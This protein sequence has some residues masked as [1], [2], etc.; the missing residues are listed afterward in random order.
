MTR[1]SFHT[2]MCRSAFEW[3]LEESSVGFMVLRPNLYCGLP[4]TSIGFHEHWV[5]FNP[6]PTLMRTAKRVWQLK[7]TPERRLRSELKRLLEE[8]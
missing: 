7:G 4:V 6:S 1:A 5:I 2:V 3:L 8:S